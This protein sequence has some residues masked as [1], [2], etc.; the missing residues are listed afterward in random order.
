MYDVA[1][2]V[3]VALTLAGWICLIGW[4]LTEKQQRKSAGRDNMVWARADERA[5]IS[6][7]VI[8]LRDEPMSGDQDFDDGWYE[9]CK[10]VLNQ[11]GNRDV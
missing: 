5:K 7:K 4:L 3:L 11:I 8:M 10:E 6:A 2:V 1:A 9:A